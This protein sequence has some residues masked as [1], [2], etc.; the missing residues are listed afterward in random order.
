MCAADE[1]GSSSG[2]P[3]CSAVR[4]HAPEP[5]APRRAG[6]QGH[7]HDAG[8][9]A[10]GGRQG[11]HRLLSEAAAVAPPHESPAWSPA[12]APSGGN[13]HVSNWPAGFGISNTPS[14]AWM[15][16]G[17]DSSKGC[18]RASSAPVLLWSV[19]LRAAPFWTDDMRPVGL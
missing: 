13:G 6:A 7:A 19:R 10:R 14:P 3:R 16:S 11:D 15:L 12:C 2:A 9:P 4:R 8:D 18:A 17:R 5:C 1:P